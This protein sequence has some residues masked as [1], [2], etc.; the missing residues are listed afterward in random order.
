VQSALDRISANGLRADVSFLASD[1]LEGRGSPS[2]GLD[3]AAEFIASQFR[4]AGLEP[5]VNGDY[6]Q[7]AHMVVKRPNLDGFR[8]ELSSGGKTVHVAPDD[9][10]AEI[11]GAIE[12]NDA[13]VVKLSADMKPED[14]NGKVVVA[15]FRELRA[16]RQLLKNA[17]PGLVVVAVRRPLEAAAPEQ[18]LVEPG[19][20]STAR[21][22]VTV[23]S[24]ELADFTENLHGAATATIHMAAPTEQPAVLRNVIG[25]LP[26]SDPALKD[27]YVLVTAH[28]DHLGMKDR[29][30]GDR[31]YNGANDDASGTSSVLEIAN[32]LA[33]L[34]KRPARTIVFMTFFGEEEGLIGSE[35][36]IHHP[37]FPLAQ[38]VAD[39]NLEHMGRSDSTEGKIAGSV[40][41][42]GYGYS[43]MLDDFKTAA[44]ESG[45]K[46]RDPGEDGDRYFPASDNYGFAEA[47]IPAHTFCAVFMFPDYHAV[48]DEWQKIDYDNMAK[49]DRMLA[50]GIVMLGDDPAAPHWNA[51]NPKVKR[52]ADA[53]K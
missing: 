3:I 34:K 52:Y 21:S 37:V 6:F 46:L 22:R 11:S 28:Y 47:G 13:P 26:G 18:T 48:G 4:R 30:E 23:F 50:L 35:Y 24:K 8:M 45:V 19:E 10:I 39:V 42:T 53:R 43:T 1:L 20:S 49:L 29:G 9:M 33:G 36:Y 2:R 12:L 5:A 44:E 41:P 40:A 25:V 31:I 7:T 51:S 14:L 17:H 38:T 16:A 15:G 32:A 27:T